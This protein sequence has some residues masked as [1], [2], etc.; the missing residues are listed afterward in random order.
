MVVPIPRL[1][2]SDVRLTYP[3][4]LAHV[5]N[6]CDYNLMFRFLQRYYRSDFVLHQSLT[7]MDFFL[8]LILV[9][10]FRYNYSIFYIF[11]FL[12]LL[13]LLLLLLLLHIFDRKL[14]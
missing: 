11:Y 8:I 12:N 9:F 5:Y 4:L 10:F 6:A 13:L 14:S 7:G 2:N 3:V 1:I